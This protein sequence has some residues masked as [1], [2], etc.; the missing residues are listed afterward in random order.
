MK[1]LINIKTLLAALTVLAASSCADEDLI[2][3]MGQA[4]QL[5]IG[6]VSVGDN[7]V[8]SRA[9]GEK[10]TSTQEVSP[11]YNEVV[12]SVDQLFLNYS[13]AES[14]TSLD[15]LAIATKSE[16]R[17]SEDR[18]SID[19]T[20]DA[21]LI[22]NTKK[23][24]KWAYLQMKATNIQGDGYV[25]KVPANMG[26]IRWTTEAFED[27]LYQDKVSA[28]SDADG[29]ITI[30]NELTSSKL[31]QLTI[32][33]KHEHALLRLPLTDEKIN[34]YNIHKGTLI[35][36]MESLA[37][38]WAELKNTNSVIYV[39]LT[40]V[41]VKNV[42]YRQ[43]I[44]PV[45]YQL[46]G[47]KAVLQKPNSEYIT[48]SI[49]LKSGKTLAC[50]NQYN[51]SLN[52]TNQ[53]SVELGESN[54]PGWGQ[55]IVLQQSYEKMLKYDKT[56]NRFEVSSPNGLYELNKWMT[57]QADENIKFIEGYGNVDQTASRMSH[58]IHISQTVDFTNNI[59]AT[60]DLDGDDLSLL[61]N[62]IPLGTAEEPYTGTITVADD[63]VEIKG[64]KIHVNEANKGFVGYLG[65]GGEV[66]GLK[67]QGNFSTTE[68]HF[69]AVVGYI[70]GGVVNRCETLPYTEVNATGA[71]PYVGGIVGWNNTGLVTNC[72][73]R[74]TVYAPECGQVGGVLGENYRLDNCVITNCS[75]SGNVTGGLYVGGVVGINHRVVN[76]CHNEG[77][78]TGN[79][80]VGGVVGMSND[81]SPYYVDQNPGWPI[82]VINGTNEGEVKGKTDVGG[83]VGSHGHHSSC[84]GYIVAC[85][86][87]GKIIKLEGGTKSD[88]TNL[89]FGGVVGTNWAHK[90]YS[91]NEAVATLGNRK[92]QVIACYNTGEL[93]AENGEY[94]GGVVGYNEEFTSSTESSIK[95][96]SMVYA[97]YYTKPSGSNKGCGKDEATGNEYNYV[98]DDWSAAIS[99]MNNAIEKYKNGDYGI[100]EG[101]SN[102]GLVGSDITKQVRKYDNNTP[103]QLIDNL[104]NE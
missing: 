52:I 102:A 71:K 72:V 91:E 63:R 28:S 42:S 46:T 89:S 70:N 87:S 27:R 30:D 95:V 35:S 74:A 45:D 80:H 55:D 62:W 100:V 37:A 73:N 7:K 88:I 78:V 9:E 94:V 66:N 6:S 67:L 5:H 76:N 38:L 69:G 103:P 4:G 85:W 29:G 23:G 65:E 18:W 98:A 54:K 40:E 79:S 41:T 44:A 32:V 93:P 59:E 3:N 82:Y 92:T 50:N 64:L 24:E 47:F 97:C 22:P 14:S 49:P 99:E 31:G 34:I 57:G 56:N 53:V 20:D 25:E 2:Q 84:G 16:D 43:A 58:N 75:N 104:S 13:F 12:T 60:Y 96:P 68:Q 81:A 11:K 36:G 15:K 90:Y 19:A 17:W 39:P 33:L 86:N 26:I 1:K 10:G 21:A 8:A 101:P 51:L 61:S 48:I 77:T 83:V